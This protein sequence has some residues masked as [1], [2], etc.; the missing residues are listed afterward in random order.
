MRMTSQ[1]ARR[2]CGSKPGRGLVEEDQ[3]RVA[4]EGEREVQPPGLAAAERPRAAVGAVVEAR[5][6]EHLGHLARMWVHAGPVRD[7]LAD[8]QMRVG[9]AALQ[10]DPDLRPQRTVLRVASEHADLAGVAVPVA[11]EHLDARRLSGAVGAEQAEHLTA[12][13]GEID[14]AQRRQ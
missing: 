3:L 11:L 14:P 4:D 10:D 7:R 5:E 1:A 8:G 13:D 6:R 9:A 2:A 12:L